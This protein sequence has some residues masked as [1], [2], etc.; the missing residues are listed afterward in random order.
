MILFSKAQADIF[1]SRNISKVELAYRAV[2]TACGAR[3]F[4]GDSQ[5]LSPGPHLTP[6]LG[7]RTALWL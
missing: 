5:P 2:R 4:G 7:Q 1:R 3:E 6:T